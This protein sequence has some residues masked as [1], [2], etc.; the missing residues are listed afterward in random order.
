MKPLRYLFLRGYELAIK[1]RSQV[2]WFRPLVL[3]SALNGLNALVVIWVCL[4]LWGEDRP[5]A[6]QVF[7]SRLA[8]VLWTILVFLT[9][10]FRWIRNGRYLAFRDEFNVESV[11]QRRLRTV[12]MF[13]YVIISLCAPAMVGY[14]VHVR[15]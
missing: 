8:I 10:Y 2:P 1:Q 4:E 13:I 12:V 15:D 6:H 11:A 7:A 9:L 5:I 14:W 3:L